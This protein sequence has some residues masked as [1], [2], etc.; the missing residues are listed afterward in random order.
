MCDWGCWLTPSKSP[1]LTVEFVCS[2]IDAAAQILTTPELLSI[3]VLHKI[4]SV[5]SLVK[6][7]QQGRRC[8]MNRLSEVL[9]KSKSK[10][11][12]KVCENHRYINTVA[13]L[14][15]EKRILQD[16]RNKRRRKTS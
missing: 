11:S 5:V 16:V 4:H 9:G 10:T 1:A 2:I 6:Q 15:A 13:L 7:S 14:V 8:V 3:L 12:H